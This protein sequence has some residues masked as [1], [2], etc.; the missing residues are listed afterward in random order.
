M[1]SRALGVLPHVFPGMGHGMM[2]E[3]DWR[4]VA[5]RVLD[6]LDETLAGSVTDEPDCQTG[7]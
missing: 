1:T 4:K 3:A 7:H 2:L 6:W 5:Q